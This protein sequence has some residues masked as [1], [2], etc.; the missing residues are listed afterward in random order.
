[1]VTFPIIIPQKIHNFFLYILNENSDQNTTRIKL[2]WIFKTEIDKLPT[3]TKVKILGDI[4]RWL[5]FEDFN[6]EIRMYILLW[7][8]KTILGIN[9][10]EGYFR[11]RWLLFIDWTLS[12]PQFPTIICSLHFLRFLL[13]YEPKIGE[14]FLVHILQFS[15]ENHQK[16]RTIFWQA[17]EQKFLKIEIITE[18]IVIS[19]AIKDEIIKIMGNIQEPKLEFNPDQESQESNSEEQLIYELP[20]T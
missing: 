20:Q 13:F 3:L 14:D 16:L 19:K 12:N 6:L 11:M 15:I 10:N 7:L 8:V 18:N 1:M 2:N 17:H 9:Q 5:I 4:A